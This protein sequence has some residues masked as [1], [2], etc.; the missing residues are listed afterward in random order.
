MTHLAGTQDQL[1]LLRAPENM[2]T[3]GNMPEYLF[4]RTNGIVG[5]LRRLIADGCA[6]AMST[7]E[8]RLTPE[9][10]SQVNLRLGNFPDVDLEADEMPDIPAG[11]VLENPPKPRRK[12]P[13]NTV[14]DD[15][16]GQAAAGE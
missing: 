1:R 2:L 12:K 5:L 4:R 7:G 16:G 13:R 15:R 8:E 3:G 11:P 6:H 14:F 9:I 10:L